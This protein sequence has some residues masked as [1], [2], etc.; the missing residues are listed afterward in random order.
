MKKSRL[1]RSFAFY[2]TEF[3][4]LDETLHSVQTLFSMFETEEFQIFE[5]S[6]RELLAYN[7]F[8]AGTHILS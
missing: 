1:S 8:M 5:M 7:G 2:S 3:K 4:I 6:M